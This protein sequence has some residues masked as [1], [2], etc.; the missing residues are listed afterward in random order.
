MNDKFDSFAE[1]KHFQ[2]DSLNIISKDMLL[3]KDFIA[4][5]KVTARDKTSERSV[6]LGLGIISI[7][8]L[9]GV[10]QLQ[11]SINL[12]P[13][14]SNIIQTDRQSSKAFGVAS[15]TFNQQNPKKLIFYNS[16]IEN[17]IKDSISHG[18]F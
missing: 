8:L 13:R 7:L 9:L 2:H 6:F 10:I 4:L 3:T 12:I 1:L 15:E 16:V 5:S 11:R 18:K 14:E 17:A